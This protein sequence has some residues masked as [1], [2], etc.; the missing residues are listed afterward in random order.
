ML[1]G[2]FTYFVRACSD[3]ASPYY[4][5]KKVRCMILQRT[6]SVYHKKLL[7]Q[8]ENRHFSGVAAAGP[9]FVTRV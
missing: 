7:Q 1:I 3:S 6:F 2:W 5:S 4:D 9:S 8:L